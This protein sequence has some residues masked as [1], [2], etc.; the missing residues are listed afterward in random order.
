MKQLLPLVWP[1]TVDIFSFYTLLRVVLFYFFILPVRLFTLFFFHY[2]GVARENNDGRT[3][4]W[5]L[6][7]R[8]NWHAH[9]HTHIHASIAVH[10]CTCVYLRRA[11][12]FISEHLV[13]RPFRRRSETISWAPA[14]KTILFPDTIA[15]AAAARRLCWCCCVVVV[16]VDQAVHIIILLFSLQCRY[17][18]LYYLHTGGAVP[19]EMKFGKKQ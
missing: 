4:Y 9:T 16:V 19:R 1:R 14:N 18:L 6:M 8:G 2:T 15:A 3:N 5:L 12:I 10:T 11:F 17:T 7:S 13:A